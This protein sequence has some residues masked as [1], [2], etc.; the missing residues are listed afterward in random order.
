MQE[1]ESLEGW[2]RVRKERI[3]SLQHSGRWAF[4][5]RQWAWSQAERGAREGDH[6][7]DILTLLTVFPRRLAKPTATNWLTVKSPPGLQWVYRSRW[8][9]WKSEGKWSGMGGRG[10]SDGERWH[11]GGAAWPYDLLLI[12][13]LRL[14][15]YPLV[16][17]VRLLLCWLC[18]A[19]LP[20]SVCVEAEGER[21][22][23]FLSS[24]WMADKLANFSL[25]WK[26]GSFKN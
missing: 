26:I 4:P 19:K 7:D 13:S 8:A 22:Q 5:S 20:R 25:N 18:R 2:V 23:F 6:R 14:T 21:N 3:I 15:W 10:R 1:N 16:F 24:Q 17:C 11:S 9:G 12:C